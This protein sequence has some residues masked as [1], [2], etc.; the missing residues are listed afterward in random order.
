[1]GT[2]F[3]LGGHPTYP[4]F[5][6]DQGGPKRAARLPLG[7]P[8]APAVGGRAS[9]PAASATLVRLAAE[10]RQRRAGDENMAGKRPA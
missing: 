10:D 3:H 7:R 5:H 4:Q 2:V 1:L 9:G 6:F 8:A